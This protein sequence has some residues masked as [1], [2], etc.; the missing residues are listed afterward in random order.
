MNPTTSQPE[1]RD[2]R[3]ALV[4]TATV[5]DVALPVPIDRLFDYRVPA[6]RGGPRAELV[7][8][9][10]LQL[11]VKSSRQWSAPSTTARTT[12][13]ASAESAKA[14]KHR[15]DVRIPANRVF[16]GISIEE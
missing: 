11:F 3:P 5:A 7:G 13:A 6:A 14:S 10:A 8:A 1:L 16:I 15:P 12:G 2:A 4:Q 9:T